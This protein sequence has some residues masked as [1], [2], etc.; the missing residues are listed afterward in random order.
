MMPVSR[1]CTEILPN[2]ERRPGLSL[3]EIREIHA[4][5]LL[6][7]PGA[8][9]TTAFEME[10][11]AAG[12]Q[13]VSAR[14]FI[15]L[16]LPPDRT[17]KPIFIDG[18]DEVR[19][20]GTDNMTPLD[21]IRQNLVRIGQPVF[22]LSC[23]EADWLG[24]DRDRLNAIT[25][26]GVR[27]FHLDDLTDEQ[28]RCILSLNLGVS[29]PDTFIE[30][31]RDRGLEALLRN[32]QSLGLLAE[33]VQGGWPENLK[34][35][36]EL[37]CQRLVT[38]HNRQHRD[39]TRNQR[40]TPDAL[41]GAAGQL[42]AVQ[43]LGGLAGFALD[44]D[45]ADSAYPTLQSVG[46]LVTEAH[47]H[48]L[49]GRLFEGRG[50]EDRREATH[51][52]IAEF[53]A[54]RY[55]ANQIDKAGLPLSRV[56]S[57][58]TAGDGGVVSD[59]R[60]LHAWLAALCPGARNALIEADPL[61]TVL[62][63]DVK[64]F[65]ANDKRSVLDAL[66]REAQRYPWF[67]SQDWS[68]PPF[69]ALADR[70]SVACFRDILESRDRNQAHESL[71]DCVLEAIRH[72][73]TLPEISDTLLAVARDDSR[74]PVNRK[75]AVEALIHTTN[76]LPGPLRTLL[77]DITGG[78]VADGDDELTGMLLGALYPHHASPREILAHLHPAKAPQLIGHYRMFWSR[79]FLERTPASELPA[80]VDGFA[81]ALK[82]L[83]P[84][85]NDF[86]FRHLTGEL[87]IKALRL[88]GESATPERVWRWLGIGLD[89]HAH[90]HLDNGHQTQISDWLSQHSEKLRA[91]LEFAF[92]QCAKTKDVL[93]CLFETER[94]IYD[95]RIPLDSADWLFEQAARFKSGKARDYL[96]NWGA[97]ALLRHLEYTPRLLDALLAIAAR[98]PE[99]RPNV[100]AWL[101]SDWDDWRREDAQWKRSRSS[102]EAKR[103]VEWQAFLRAHHAAVESGTAHPK[104]MNDLAMVYFGRFQ[105]TQGENPLTRLQAWF[106]RDAGM[107]LTVL[108]GLQ[109][110]LE[111][112]DLPTVSEI[113][114][115]AVDGRHH[116]IAE[117]CLAGA[118]ELFRTKPQQ[119][120]SLDDGV[121]ARLIC[122]RLTHD[123]QDTPAWFQTVVEQR[124][125]VVA[126]V[127]VTYASAM[128][129]AG[130][131]HVAGIFPL[132]YDDRYG[133]VGRLA[134]LKLLTAYPTRARRERQG[135]LGSLLVAALKHGDRQELA[136]LIATKLSYKSLDLAQRTLWLCAGL[137]LDPAGYEQLLSD[138]IEG[139]QA[140]SMLAAGFFG[141][142]PMQATGLP[143]L[144]ESALAM[145]IRSIGPYTTPERPN[146]AHR[147][148][149]AMNAADLV[150]ALIGRL[151]NCASD[152][153]SSAFSALL[154]DESLLA[155][156]DR[157]REHHESQRVIIREARF[158]YPSAA[159]I[160]KLL[161]NGPP[162]NAA[163]LKALI[164]QHLRDIGR[165]DRDGNKTGYLRYWNTDKDDKPIEAKTENHC[166]DR[167]LE[168]LEERIRSLGVEM[169][170]E[171]EYREN[172]RADIRASFGGVGGFNVPI[173]IKRDSHKELWKAWRTQLLAHYVRDPGA[174]GH[175]IYLVFW[176]GGEGMPA[177]ADGGKPP[178]RADEL[179]S[180]L[181][182]MLG[183][184]EKPFIDV[185]V[186]DCART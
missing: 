22:R 110:T 146:G 88:S 27:V 136:D 131:D 85:L 125:Q 103:I 179:E 123:Y 8:G 3:D 175:G 170:P 153:A 37:A 115:L 128:L 95:A 16:A 152:T 73:D 38:E 46:L 81:E 186:L 159:A 182:A 173:E 167:L 101:S 138:H 97:M 91:T 157:I 39:V 140:R 154:K 100:D 151:G 134:A 23:R 60:G 144:S 13:P 49:R 84:L 44:E 1:T 118:E 57:V 31:A 185:I 87:L 65:P 45:A 172:K 171:G 43:L 132:A 169:A 82:S 47:R 139:N 69:G 168:L 29:D 119:L 107:A 28:V 14:D 112:D 70:E 59:L 90:S 18:L 21:A 15:V 181:S 24:S 76:G 7:E 20:A 165:S 35:T 106:G 30:T 17:R 164:S 41:L 145:L 143:E 92:A 155:W 166:R 149:A 55:M 120:L 80:A 9:K 62:Y 4:Y 79:D 51:R 63:G 156:R 141:E 89:A 40:L 160:A 48:A 26:Q 94:R 150:R 42:C 72:G 135:D 108:T 96:F 163:D 161:T 147:V 83:P 105:E 61:G 71:V 34:D 56:R 180:R 33:A 178:T 116:Y 58:I 109:Q 52:R 66:G 137:L 176:F 32:P 25:P 104:I 148:T 126:D 78:R 93:H 127:L 162:A 111:R 124:P 54:A 36:F 184:S 67:R 121:L 174:D 10:A 12:T 158:K 183:E 64:S 74:W 133:E 6:G 130:K 102:A 99:L 77:D 113:V 117:A 2:G 122:F 142:R 114:K 98:H 86:H 11:Q 68:A 53:L 50:N 129:K 75:S 19:A 5:V 177:A